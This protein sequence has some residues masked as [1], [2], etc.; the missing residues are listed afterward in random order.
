LLQVP[1]LSILRIL[2]ILHWLGTFGNLL[3][4]PEQIGAKINFP[5]LSIE[6]R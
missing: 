2:R 1:R 4:G 3:L 6:L 5:D